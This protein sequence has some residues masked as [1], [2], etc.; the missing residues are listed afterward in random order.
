MTPYN[1]THKDFISSVKTFAR[2]MT[3]LTADVK[4]QMALKPEKPL[5]E[6]YINDLTKKLQSASQQQARMETAYLKQVHLIVEQEE[7]NIIIHSWK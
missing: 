4:R 7:A 1:E 2:F 3:M 5:P 6:K